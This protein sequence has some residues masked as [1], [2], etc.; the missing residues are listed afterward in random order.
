[1]LNLEG[2]EVFPFRPGKI[3]IGA[4]HSLHDPVDMNRACRAVLRAIPARVSLEER[5]LEL[6]QPVPGHFHPHHVV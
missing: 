6:R 2:Q 1:M 4:T 3:G 5:C